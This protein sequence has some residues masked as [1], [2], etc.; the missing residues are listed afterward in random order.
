MIQCDWEAAYPLVW[1]RKDGHQEIMNFSEGYKAFLNQCKTEREAAAHIAA[2]A[3]AAGYADMDGVRA[4]GGTLRPGDRVLALRHNKALA[5]FVCGEAPLTDGMHLICAHLDSP[6]LDIRPNPLYEADGLALMKTHYYGGLKKY[7]WA[8]LPLAM[9]GVIVMKD[10]ARVAVSIGEAEDDPVLYVSD[11]PKHLSAQQSKQPMG[12]GI[13]GEDLNI[14]VG[15][16]PLEKSGEQGQVRKNV[17]RL[18]HERYGVTEKDFTSAELEIVPAGK[19]RD[20]GLDASMIAAYGHD[21]R[22]CVYAALQAMLLVRRPRYT[23]CLLLVDKEEVGSQG[24][25]GMKS[26]L[27]ENL[28]AGLLELMGEQSPTALRRSLEHALMLSADVT[29]AYDPNHPE[30]FEPANTARLGRGPALTKYAGHLGKKDCND[31]SAEYLA[32]LRDV[33]DDAGVCWQTGEFGKIDFGGG[34]TIAPFAAAY[35]MQVV[36]CG[37]P[38]LSMHA[39]YELASKADIYEAYRAYA[40]FYTTTRNMENYL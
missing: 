15:S 39:P 28:T 4:A 9:H 23:C 3:K 10:G 16:I 8:A 1:D 19:A 14:L 17:L 18:L 34:G 29:L 5:L 12:E 31:A 38:L 27:M 22:I 32:L 13:N 6:R 24:A 25:S 11:L 30:G 40:A 2:M 37:I 36:D 26:R 35:G 7:Q 20:A 21:D 33:F